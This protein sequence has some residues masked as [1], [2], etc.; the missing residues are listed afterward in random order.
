MPVLRV[1]LQEGFAN[2]TVV[3]RVNGQEVF[4]KTSVKTR[5]QIGLANAFEV[6]V[7]EGS[8]DIQIALPLKNVSESFELQV[9]NPIHL[10]VSITHEGRITHQISQEPFGYL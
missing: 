9:S 2:D 1:N 10:G 5:P 8:V 7:P 4:N 3:V 6:D